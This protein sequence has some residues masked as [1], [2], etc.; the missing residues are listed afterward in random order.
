MRKLTLLE[1]KKLRLVEKSI[2]SPGKQVMTE[3]LPKILWKKA[4]RKIKGSAW[5]KQE[6][7]KHHP[8]YGQN[9]CES[10]GKIVK[11]IERHELYGLYQLDDILL[12]KYEGLMFLCKDCHSIVHADFTNKRLGYVKSVY[13]ISTKMRDTLKWNLAEYILIGTELY[14]LGD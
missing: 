2:N 9:I 7:N 6:A 11:S 1:A 10:C 13:P 5:F 12:I 14:S 4:P 3:N 8:I